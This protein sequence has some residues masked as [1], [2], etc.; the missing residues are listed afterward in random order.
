MPVSHPR[1]VI[2][3]LGAVSSIGAGV[4]AF[5]RALRAGRSGVRPLDFTD[6]HMVSTVAAKVWPDVFDPCSVMDDMDQRR[7]PRLVPMALAAAREAMGQAGMKTGEARNGGAPEEEGTDGAVDRSRRIGLILGTGA[8]GIDFTLDQFHTVHRGKNASLWTITNATHGNLAGELSIRLGLRGPSWCISTGCA[9]SSDAAGMALQQ[10]RIARDPDR[11]TLDGMVVVGADAHVRWETL[12][13]MELLKVIT[14]RDWRGAG[15]DPATASRPFDATRDGFVLGEGA[16]AIVLEREET[17]RRREAT[18]LGE[19]LGYGAT[20]DAF[21]RVRPAPDMEESARAMRLTIADAGVHPREIEVLHYH[22]TSTKVNDAAETMA[23]KMAFGDGAGGDGHARRLVGTSV[24][25]QI[26]HPQGAC[27]LA[28]L[29]ATLAGLTN[30]DQ[31]EGSFVAP[32]INLRH[33][34]PECDLDYTPNAPAATRARTAL[35]NC[36]AFGAKNSAL[37]VRAADLRG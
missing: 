5:T 35:I 25:S 34:D 37:V 22:G 15:E 29:V 6:P 13:G 2:T 19:L 10:L 18:V 9:S 36:L 26:G 32:T 14:T 4:P 28:A 24:K 20:C 1:V 27:G 7:L 16:W 31:G 30:Q 21:H 23:V 3:G 11:G 8:G 12:S 33:A 17:A